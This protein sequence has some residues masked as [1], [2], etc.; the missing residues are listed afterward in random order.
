MKARMHLPGDF[1][2]VVVG[3]V[4]PALDRPKPSDKA[5]NL[6]NHLNSADA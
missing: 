2:Q 5:V 6:P 3:D 1:E 4:H